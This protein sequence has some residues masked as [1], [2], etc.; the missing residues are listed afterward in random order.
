MRNCFQVE[1]DPRL[2]TWLDAFKHMSTNIEQGLGQDGNA[3]QQARAHGSGNGERKRHWKADEDQDGT[4]GKKTLRTSGI[5]LHDAICN[6]N[7]ALMLFSNHE[8]ECSVPVFL[9]Y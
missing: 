3:S 1:S 5:F 4:Y 8:T 9:F 7:K 6:I 2:Y